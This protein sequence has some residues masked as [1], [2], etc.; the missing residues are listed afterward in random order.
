M[1]ELISHCCKNCLDICEEKW[2]WKLWGQWTSRRSQLFTW[3]SCGNVTVTVQIFIVT[4]IRDI[5]MCI[6]IQLTQNIILLQNIPLQSHD[7]NWR[8]T[9]RVSEWVVSL[10]QSCGSK[11]RGSGLVCLFVTWD[12]N[13]LHYADDNLVAISEPDQLTNV[14]AGCH[15]RNC[16][17]AWP[18]NNA[19]ESNHAFLR[20][21][22][23]RC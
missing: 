7:C 5:R 19:W 13:I 16:R 17:N 15:I 9:E 20:G 10:L 8:K 18:F 21:P 1:A 3:A 14:C 4:I 12:P 23:A 22:M 2:V 11:N 6:C